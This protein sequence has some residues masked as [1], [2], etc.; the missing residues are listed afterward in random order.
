MQR[1]KRKFMGEG[2]VIKPTPP[3]PAP[4]MVQS[5]IEPAPRPMQNFTTY[6][7][8][9]WLHTAHS[10]TVE[11]LRVAAGH[12]RFTGQNGQDFERSLALNTLEVGRVYRVIGGEIGRNCTYLELEG[13]LPKRRWNSVM[14]DCDTDTCNLHDPYAL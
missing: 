2:N 12:A 5:W 7:T 13:D 14:F 1:R 10:T 6:Q 4:S 3:P 8:A 9:G 11:R